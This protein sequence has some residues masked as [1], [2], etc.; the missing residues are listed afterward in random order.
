MCK[1]TFPIEAQIKCHKVGLCRCG[2][3]SKTNIII[4][5]ADNGDVLEM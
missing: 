4:Y 5:N 2:D 3:V 1:N